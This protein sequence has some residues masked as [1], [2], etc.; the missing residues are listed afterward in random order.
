MVRFRVFGLCMLAGIVVSMGS[1]VQAGTIYDNLSAVSNGSDPITSENFGPLAD[2]FS[3][4]A[5]TTLVDVKL[6]LSGDPTVA[7]TT[8]VYLL[9][10][11]STSPGSV[12]ATLGTIDDSALS[13]NGS[14]QD[15]S[16]FAP[17]SL[18]ANTR[19]W[20]ELTST[21]NASSNWNFSTDTSGVGVANE[22]F[23]NQGG[24]F[25]N[26]QKFPYQ[27]QI[28]TAGAAVPEPATLTLAAFGLGGVFLISRRV[29]R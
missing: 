14:V 3:T 8:T 12:L 5:A 27:M 7:G 10:D 29:A 16:G 22:Y 9:S 25:E 15:V 13:I 21:D 23:S 6:L 1:A 26:S 4:G 2:S 11:A 17:F 20:I 19:Y 18:S 24:V 28:N